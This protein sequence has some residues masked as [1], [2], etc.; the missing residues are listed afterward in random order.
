[1]KKMLNGKKVVSVLLASAMCIGLLTACGG[2]ETTTED[3]YAT[4]LYLYNWSEYMTEDVKDAF[5]E[6]YGI[7]VIES[8]YES[9]DELLAKLLAG[10]NDGTYDIAVPS[11]FYVTTLLANDLLVAYDATSLENY[12]NID[13]AYVGLEYDAENQ[14]SVPYM[15]TLGVWIGNQ[16]ILDEL[17]VEINSMDDLTDPA[18]EDN[19][20]FTDDSQQI[21]EAGLMGAGLDP[22]SQDV[23]DIDAAKE[24][25]LSINDNVKSYSVTVDARDAMARGEAAVAYMY[26][27]EALQAM[28][29]NPDLVV[30]MEEEPVSLSLDTFVILEGSEHVEE[31]KLFID[32]CL[33]EDISAQLTN[34]YM[35]TC[36][37]TAAVDYLDE[38]LANSPLCVMD[39][40][41]KD[42]MFYYNSLDA[43][44]MAAEID[45]ITE[46]KASR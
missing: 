21:I 44:F 15:G 38:E 13:S 16:A 14:Y 25:L 20:I 19:I 30:V 8:T 18:L 9:N 27:G 29:E 11:N 7:K 37:N 4:E 36:F 6:E 5:E 35:F 42:N 45:A 2:K 17:G 34:E 26:S 39:D 22:S 33:R 10:G 12:E 31:A 23:D 3:G 41:I 28:M 40:S 43:D 1:M 32:F 46:I 24:F